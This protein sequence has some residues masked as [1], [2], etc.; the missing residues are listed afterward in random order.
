MELRD[1]VLPLLR[2]GGEP[3]NAHQRQKDAGQD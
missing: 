2:L 1:C 3:A